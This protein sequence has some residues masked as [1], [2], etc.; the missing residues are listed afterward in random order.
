MYQFSNM[1]Q[2]ELETTL[3]K[4]L[5]DFNALTN[6]PLS[7][8]EIKKNVDA[9]VRE[10]LRSSATRGTDWH[11][12]APMDIVNI[13]KA[14]FT[15]AGNNEA[16][17]DFQTINDDV[18][19][20]CTIFKKRPE[21]LLHWSMYSSQLT[22]LAKALNTA[23]AGSG[24]EWT[25]TGY[26]DQMFRAMEIE[27]EIAVEFPS[28]TMPT[29]PYVFPLLVTDPTT[30]LSGEA[31]T[32]SPSMYKASSPTTDNVTF[33]AKK[34]TTNTPISEEVEE[35]SFVD[36]IGEIKY[37]IARSQ[38][39]AED[40]AI[41][42][43]DTSTNHLDTGYTVASDDNRRAWNGLRDICISTLKQAGSS[44]STSAGLGI[45]RGVREDMEVYGSASKDLRVICNQNALTKMRN[46]D[47][48][49]THDKFGSSATV[50]KG[51]L[52]SIDG[53][54]IVPTRW[55]EERQNA[56]GLYDGTTTTTT[57]ILL[58]NTRAFRRGIRKK[59][60]IELVRKPLQG[61]MY[62]CAS[63][64][65]HWRCLYDVETE[66]VTGWIYNI[67]K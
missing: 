63:T 16:L 37:A 41:I 45:I 46:L 26:S 47:E 18:Y 52:S 38:A 2:E 50:T 27:S 10:I 15:P 56:T 60:K 43:G 59:F 57:Q 29:N 19:T 66:P 48:V 11:N 6:S 64:R 14:L 17:H 28:I 62:L 51:D 23:D 22:S 1:E 9:N 44:W 25:P 33:T 49:S 12:V 21:E 36:I 8:A 5:N 7:E 4:L 65:K 30:Y 3:T 58:V 61:N 32:D 42:N 53:M 40:N 24:S 55:L 67:S 54:R 13:Q 31:T 39:G 20:T 35:D 34:L